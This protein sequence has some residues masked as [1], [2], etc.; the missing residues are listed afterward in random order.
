VERKTLDVDPL[1]SCDIIWDSLSAY[2]D[3]AVSSDESALVE[4][5]VATC[6]ECA[7][8]LRFMRE[9]SLVLSEM[10]A[11]SPPPGLKDA[12]LSATIYRPTWRQRMARSFQAAFTPVQMRNFAGAGAAGV[13]LGVMISVSR[14]PTPILMPEKAEPVPKTIASTPKTDF[15]KPLPIEKAKIAKAGPVVPSRLPVIHAPEQTVPDPSNEVHRAVFRTP[16]GG[17]PL[18]SAPA[19]ARTNPRATGTRGTGRSPFRPVLRPKMDGDMPVEPMNPD[20]MNRPMPMGTEM[21]TVKGMDH[22]TG[23]TNTVT[24]PGTEAVASAPKED[25]HIV[26]TSNNS[27][28]SA[29]SL[30]TFADLRSSLRKSE[31]ARGASLECRISTKPQMWDVYKSHF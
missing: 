6:A 10:P 1:N 29:D 21:A 15:G 20:P 31:T 28:S 11:V 25:S 17:A 22:A 4:R 14:T 30:V 7:R 23:D 3:G 12:I 9:A 19:S 8:D 26:L 18:T 13:L 16:V 27:A 24:R 5:H 2:V